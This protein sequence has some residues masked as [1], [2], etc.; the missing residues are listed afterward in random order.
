MLSLVDEFERGD[1]SQAE[2]CRERG[3]ALSTFLYW[4]RRAD[5]PRRRGF[6]EIE[7]V[8]PPT[9]AVRDAA[10]EIMLPGGVIVRVH[11]DADEETIR[12]VLRA[13]R[14]SC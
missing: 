4:R 7:I 6:S 5:R 1:R 14:T 12:R 11:R 3:V 2:Y 8:A 9:A 13:A 10:V